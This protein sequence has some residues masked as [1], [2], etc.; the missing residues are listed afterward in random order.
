MSKLA[1]S[2]ILI[3]SV[4]AISMAL[5]DE[6]LIKGSDTL[7]NLVQQLSEAYMEENP[8]AEISIV[9]GGSG[10]GIAA[11]IDGNIVEKVGFL[12]L[13]EKQLANSRNVVEKGVQEQ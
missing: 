6:V 9:G 8:G 12:K 10:V 2:L 3:L 7:L 13:S 11:L 5:A 1:L 4:F